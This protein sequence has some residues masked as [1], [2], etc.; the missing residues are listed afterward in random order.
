MVPGIDEIVQEISRRAQVLVEPRLKRV[1]N[2]TGVIIHTNLGR[3][4]LAEE[5]VKAIMK[6]ATGYSNLEYDL[7][8]GIR[9]SR[10]DHCTSV[11]K[12]L[13]SAGDSP[14]RQQ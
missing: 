6:V 9:G 11:L 2:A 4:V 8:K 12:R 7:E 14:R 13:T 1:I 3:S 10:H 5:A